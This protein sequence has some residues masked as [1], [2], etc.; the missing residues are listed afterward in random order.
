[1]KA[2]AELTKSLLEAAQDVMGYS[3]EEIY[4]AFDENPDAY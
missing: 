4:D 3:D 2:R 1:M